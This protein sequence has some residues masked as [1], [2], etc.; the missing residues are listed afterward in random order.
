MGMNLFYILGRGDGT[1]LSSNLIKA[2]KE[3]SEGI[4]VTIFK[5]I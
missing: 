2:L 3:A 5:D 4:T 1:T